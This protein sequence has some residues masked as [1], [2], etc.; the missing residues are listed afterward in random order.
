MQL[1]ME[2][3]LFLDIDPDKAPIRFPPAERLKRFGKEGTPEYQAKLQKY[4]AW[5]V[6]IMVFF[7][8]LFLNNFL[9]L[10]LE[11]SLYYKILNINVFSS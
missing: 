6:R 1:L 8:K 11:E 10:L 9:I 5:T 7:L 3:E 2:E 4:R